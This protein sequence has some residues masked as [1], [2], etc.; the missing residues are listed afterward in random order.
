[1]PDTTARFLAMSAAPHPRF[2]V[3]R[4]QTVRKIQTQT[5][6]TPKRTRSLRPNQQERVRSIFTPIRS[7]LRTP[8]LGAVSALLSMLLSWHALRECS[9]CDR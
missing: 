7:G 1:M 6:P 9:Q 5:L 3:G 2:S 4:D 8:T